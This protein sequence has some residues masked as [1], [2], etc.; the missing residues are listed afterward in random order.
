MKGE[1]DDDEMEV[2][3]REDGKTIRSIDK[4][5]EIRIK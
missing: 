5:M 1:K 3:V 4:G 2:L